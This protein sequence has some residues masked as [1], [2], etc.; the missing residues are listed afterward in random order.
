MYYNGDCP[1]IKLFG[2]ELNVEQAVMN[3]KLVRIKGVDVLVGSSSVFY[4]VNNGECKIV[5]LNDPRYYDIEKNEN[6]VSIRI[7]S[8]DRKKSMRWEN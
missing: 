5:I 1:A 2:N 3:V 8:E 4:N 6:S 7:S